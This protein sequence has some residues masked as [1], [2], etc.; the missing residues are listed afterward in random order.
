VERL[1]GAEVELLAG[2]TSLPDGT[3]SFDFGNTLVGGTATQVFTVNNVGVAPLTVQPVSLP[4]GFSFVS[5]L[6]AGQV[7]GAGASATFEVSVNSGTPGSFSG[8]LQFA[9]DDADENPFNITI[10]ATVGADPALIIDNGQT[11]FASTGFN[12][13]TAA[14]LGQFNNNSHFTAGDN[15]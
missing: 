11:G 12:L 3:G 5:N 15:T 9:N 14:N 1:V 10:T 6:G 13:Y 2:T 7:I 8:T 4:A